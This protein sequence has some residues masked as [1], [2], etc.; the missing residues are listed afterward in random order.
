[1]TNKDDKIPKI[2]ARTIPEGEHKRASSRFE[3]EIPI[4]VGILIP[5][6]TFQPHALTG[7]TSDVSATGMKIQLDSLE[8]EL[9]RKLMA[10]SRMVRLTFAPPGLAEPIKVTGKIA[11]MDY[12]KTDSGAKTA[13]C[14]LG[15]FFSKDEGVDLTQYLDF[16]EKIEAVEAA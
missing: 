12:R 9:Y 14:H 10:R 13:P 1:M 8:A 4:D 16:I 5:E 2:K 6:E 11:W 7:G 3:I 15:I